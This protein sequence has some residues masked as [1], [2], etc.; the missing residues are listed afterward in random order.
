MIVKVN[1]SAD[2]NLSQKEFE[3]VGSQ[4]RDCWKVGREGLSA[5]FDPAQIPER[6][7][8]LTQGKGTKDVLTIERIDFLR[9]LTTSLENFLIYSMPSIDHPENHICV[10]QYDVSDAIPYTIISAMNYVFN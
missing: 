4:A 7:C 2:L 5:Y 3:R 9:G 1:D 10:Y 6:Q 8:H